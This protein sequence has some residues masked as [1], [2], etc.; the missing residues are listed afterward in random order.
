MK[1]GR[2]K[3]FRTLENFFREYR[4]YRCDE[5]GQVVKQQDLLMNCLRY[6]CVYG[7]DRMRKEPD[8]YEEES[9]STIPLGTPDAWMAY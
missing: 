9:G 6:L 7:R 4:L 2:L 5:Q 1:S 3:V 8:R